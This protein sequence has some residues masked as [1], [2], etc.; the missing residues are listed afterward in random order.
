MTNLMSRDYDSS[1]CWKDIRQLDIEGVEISSEYLVKEV[2]KG[3]ILEDI[4]LLKHYRFKRG[5]FDKDNLFKS[6]MLTRGEDM[7]VGECGKEDSTP[8]IFF[9]CTVFTGIW[10]SIC[11]WIEVI[12]VFPNDNW[13]HV[14]SLSNDSGHV[15][16]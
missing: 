14:E 4:P 12:K 11:N 8:L 6:G 2:Y 5:M 1:S 13:Q 3:L 10:S 7:C 15:V 16:L 9:E